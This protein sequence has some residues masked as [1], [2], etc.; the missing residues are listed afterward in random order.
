MIILDYGT[1]VFFL[2]FFLKMNLN[3]T[4][5]KAAVRFFSEHFFLWVYVSLKKM[6]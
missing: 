6:R 4:T 1:S 5:L 2:L 3:M